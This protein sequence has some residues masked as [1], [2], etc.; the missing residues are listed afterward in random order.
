MS[1]QGLTL[2]FHLY[3]TNSLSDCYI[4]L[5]KQCIEKVADCSGAGKKKKPTRTSMFGNI[6]RKQSA[7]NPS[8]SESSIHSCRKNTSKIC[9]FSTVN[10]LS[11][12]LFEFLDDHGYHLNRIFKI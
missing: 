6:M 9:F 7:N 8:A 12:M 4:N 5:H 2:S 1:N 11:S 3:L 10:C